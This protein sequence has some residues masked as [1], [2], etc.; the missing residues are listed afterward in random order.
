MHGPSKLIAR[1]TNIKALQIGDYI[2]EKRE[3][4]RARGRLICTKESLTL[5][6]SSRE[7]I[8]FSWF[9]GEVQMKR[10]H[11]DG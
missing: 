11:Q 6:D 3:R 10:A 8:T 1:Q 7:I 2:M 5:F 4:A 9:Q